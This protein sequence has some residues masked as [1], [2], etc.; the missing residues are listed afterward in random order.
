M[1]LRLLLANLFMFLCCFTQILAQDTTNRGTEF[2]VGYGHHQAM[3]SGSNSQEMT[4]Y[5]STGS[6]A[7]VVTLT[8]DSSGSTPASSATWWQKI[9]NVPAN[10]VINVQTAGAG[11][12]KSG[13]YDARLYSPAAP[14]GSYSAG[15]FRGK[16][17]RIQSNVPVA[18]YA[19]I[20][21][22][23]SSGAT[24]LLPVE[25]WGG[26]YYSANSTQQYAADAF[27]WMYIIARY[28]NTVIQVTPTVKTRGQDVTGLQPGVTKTITLMKGQIYQVMG[29]NINSDVNGN[30][31]SGAVAYEL[32]GTRVQSVSSPT[33]YTHPIAVFS[34]SSRTSNPMS[35]GGSSGDNDMQ[36]HFP[37]QALGKLYLT[38]PTSQSSAASAFMTNGY[39]IVV[40]DPA[41]IVT[42]NGVALTGLINNSYYQFESN[43]AERIEADQPVLLAQFMGSGGC[44]GSLGD[45]EM[46]YISP[47]SQAINSAT[48]YRNTRD[49]I[50]INYLT[51][52]IPTAGLA[53]LTIDGSASYD[54]SYAHPQLAGYTVVVKKWAAAQAACVVESASPFTGITYGLGS[55]ES[56]GY[57]IGTKLSAVNARDAS[58]LPSGFTGEV[59]PVT[60]LGF[61]ATK[62]NNDVLLKWNTANEINLDRFELQRSLNG[63]SFSAIGAVQA[64]ASAGSASYS[65]VDKD[66]LQSSPRALFYRLK[67]IDKDGSYSYSGVV[68]VRA[69]GVGVQLQASPN[70]F[71]NQLSIQVQTE[72]AGMAQLTLRDLSGKIIESR[73]LFMHPGSSMVPFS[74]VSMLPKGIYLLELELNGEKLYQKLAH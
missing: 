30:G 15:L 53:T 37:R 14:A 70:P 55:V 2:W 16:A 56:Y 27:S 6:Q 63:A 12:P 13:S 39:K 1:R 32:T 64:S 52:I 48:F 3:E 60:L 34:G 41:T 33:G 68:I 17:I 40:G 57:N 50:S 29:A 36:Q 42:R 18:A 72:K 54:H 65:L 10:T 66:A 59:F 28:D 26:L 61:T 20:Y 19:H 31:G 43:A 47:L 44:N 11:I 46:F 62:T 24:M 38:A 4:I 9:I 73:A 7:A 51:L 69:S 22:T 21:S 8:L 58:V 5:I 45:P 25:A 49:A 71:T 23:T 74:N 67:M 35:C